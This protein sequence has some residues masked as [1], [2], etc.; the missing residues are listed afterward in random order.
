LSRRQYL[1]GPGL[2]LFKRSPPLIGHLEEFLLVLRL[3][4][5]VLLGLL[6]GQ[7]LPDGIVSLLGQF[8]APLSL[9]AW[10]AHD[11]RPDGLHLLTLLGGQVQL[12]G[13]P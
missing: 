1:L 3:D 6:V 12:V 8:G 7:Q 9:I 10:P 11:L 4:L 5:V 2:R 13:K